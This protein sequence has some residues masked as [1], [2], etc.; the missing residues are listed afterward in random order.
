M[1]KF[2]AA[3]AAAI[4][5]P[6]FLA[7]ACQKDQLTVQS[8]ATPP[9]THSCQRHMVDLNVD[10]LTHCTPNPPG[11]A[12]FTLAVCTCDTLV[13][14]P[15]NIPADYTFEHWIIQQ[16]SEE[17][18][19]SGLVLDTITVSSELWLE[20]HRNA[21]NVHLRIDVDVNPCP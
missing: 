3:T 12:K 4:A 19:N 6:L 14:N 9:G 18:E 8:T 15:V 11:S 21:Q 17:G 10:S 5:I 7:S 16:G 1:I 13:L 20:F 2:R